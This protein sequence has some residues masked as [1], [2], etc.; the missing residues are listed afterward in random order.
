MNIM[1]TGGATIVEFMRRGMKPTDA[2]LETLKH[3]IAMTDAAHLT[4]DKKPRYQLNFYATNKKGEFG[5]ASFYP[6]PF[7]VHD[8]TEAKTVDGAHLFDGPQP[9]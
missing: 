6:A 9:S 4:A 3:V 8:G 7:A 2:C 1:G 5:C